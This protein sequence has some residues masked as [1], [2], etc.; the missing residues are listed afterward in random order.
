MNLLTTAC[1]CQMTFFLQKKNI[2]VLLKSNPIIKRK[3]YLDINNQ[4]RCKTTPANDKT[5]AV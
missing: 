1:L 2:P 5:Y 3:V 4:I